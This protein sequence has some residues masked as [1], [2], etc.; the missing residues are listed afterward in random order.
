MMRH[1]MKP[2]LLTLIALGALL[3]GSLILANGQGPDA[4]DMRLGRGG[5]RNPL[6]RMTATLN[7]TDEEQAKIQP[8]VD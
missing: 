1:S 3:L 5:G 7:L 4:R 2:R 8:I 6:E